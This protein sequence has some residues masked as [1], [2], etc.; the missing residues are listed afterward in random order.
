MSTEKKSEKWKTGGNMPRT[1]RV[2]EKNK[3]KKCFLSISARPQLFYAAFVS[4]SAAAGSS[5]R[6]DTSLE[7]P[8]SCI[9]TP[10]RTE[11][12]SIVLRL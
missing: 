1:R 5:Q 11:A 8:G 3:K 10:Y 7:T 4:A 9:V 6:T 12:I 2:S